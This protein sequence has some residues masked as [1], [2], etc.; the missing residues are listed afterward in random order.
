MKMYLQVYASSL[1]CPVSQQ[2]NS[3]SKT[4][5][6]TYASYALSI[7]TNVLITEGIVKHLEAKFM[8]VSDRTEPSGSTAKLIDLTAE[9]SQ[10]LN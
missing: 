7:N 8:Q 5:L 9:L 10:Q 2:T 1:R 3:T 4:E 6:I